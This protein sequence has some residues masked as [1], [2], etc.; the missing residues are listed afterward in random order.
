MALITEIN[1]MCHTIEV[2]LYPNYLGKGEDAET[3]TYRRISAGSPAIVL[4]IQSI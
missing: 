4:R 2:K 1:D 3:N